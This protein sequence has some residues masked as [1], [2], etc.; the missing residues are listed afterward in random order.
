MTESVVLQ[1]GDDRLRQEAQPVK[2]VL[3]PEI[4]GVIEQLLAVVQA[5]NGV[6][7]AA[8]QIAQPLQIMVV[9]SHPSARYPQAPTMAPL[10]LINPRIVA[11]RGDRILGWEGCL[12]VS[13]QRGLVPRYGE[14]V[15]EFIN[16]Q[17]LAETV[18]F[19]DF[20]SRIFQHEYDHLQGVLFPDRVESATNLISEAE[21]Q[22]LLAVVS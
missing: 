10:V 20:L 21:Y 13:D 14:V 9:A 6:G 4:Q 15:V 12:S 19:Q 17:G 1:M 11:M 7:I 2:D 5:K 8:P 22:N 16:R 18:V 3:S